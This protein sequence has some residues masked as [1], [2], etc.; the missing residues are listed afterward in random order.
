MRGIVR[1]AAGFLEVRIIERQKNL[2]LSGNVIDGVTRVLADHESVIVVEDDL[3]VSPMFLPYMSEALTLYR[4]AAGVFS[5][6][7]YNYPRRILPVPG[8]YPYDAFFIMRHMCW[9][10]GTWRDR[11]RKADWEITDYSSLSQTSSWRRSFSQSGLDL[12]RMLEAQA[13]GQL[14]SW[15]IRWT[16]AHFVNHAVCLVPVES[17]VNNI[18]VDGSGTH[19]RPS[20]RY[21]H[22]SLN[23]KTG[24]RFPPHVYVDPLIARMYMTAERRSFAFRVYRRLSRTLRHIVPDFDAAGIADTRKAGQSREAGH[25][26]GTAEAAPFMRSGPVLPPCACVPMRRN[27]DAATSPRSST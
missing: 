4:F 10:W 22:R 24:M 18:G 13:Q 12:P 15:A 9:G 14:D 2:G 8:D 21:F 16:Y 5:V 1:A 11:W 19:M 3:V 26:A 25:G 27:D 23:G 20:A 7:G 6:S 17:F